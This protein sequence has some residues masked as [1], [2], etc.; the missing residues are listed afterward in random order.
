MMRTDN[1]IQA[2]LTVEAA[3][4]FPAFFYAVAALCCLF[5]F[6]EVKM[7]V[8]SAMV[9]TA[10]EV[11]AYGDI[12]VKADCRPAELIGYLT[13]AIAVRTLLE[14]S[15][16]DN[17]TI[18]RVIE[19]GTAGISCAGSELLTDDE[20]IKIICSYSFSPPVS[21]FRFGRLQVSQELKYRYFTGEKVAC[22]LE[23][24][25]EEASGDDDE[26][27]VYITDK[28]KVYHFTL[29]CPALNLHIRE[30][31]AEDV[32]GARN[33]GGGKY[34]ACEKCAK[35]YKPDTLYITTDGDRYHYSIGCSGLKR[36]IKEV[37][38][39]ELQDVRG[40]KRCGKSE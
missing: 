7:T 19:G 34:Y 1:T 27:T 23:E 31:S 12:L 26:T 37:R 17:E 6:A 20:C 9:E 30:I 25:D 14:N 8:R 32:A 21:M 3:L 11:S 16:E 2:S 29:T 22:L 35:G 36:T 15:L 24:A 5:S 40:C 13:D 28:G 4:A 33:E 18:V 38:L 39:S 10:R